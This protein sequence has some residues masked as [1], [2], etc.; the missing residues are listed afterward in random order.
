[1]GRSHRSLLLSTLDGVA[2]SR[3]IL[4]GSSV[5]L[6]GGYGVSAAAYLKYRNTEIRKISNYV[7]LPK[8][9]RACR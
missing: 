7:S 8:I 3:Y 1:M 9:V 6:A 2:G 4:G 5:R